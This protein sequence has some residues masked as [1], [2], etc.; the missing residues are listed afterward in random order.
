VLIIASGL[1]V[2]TF[3]HLVSADGGFNSDRALTFELTLPAASYG[4]G[5]RI[6]NLYR[7]VLQKLQALPGVASAGIGETVPMGGAGESTGLR[8]P[9][10]PAAGDLAPP[11][12]N[13]TIVSPGYLAAVGTPML[14]G[15]DFLASDT[16]DSM[17][18]A[19]V[20]AAMAKKYWPGQDAI[21][22]QVGLPIRS[23]NMTVVGVVA[24]VKHLSLREEPGPE[25]YVPFTQ[26]PWPS[27]LTMHVA[28]RTQALPASMTGAIRSAIRE[29]D[30]A[31]PMAGVATL[32][33]IVDEAMAQPR[34]S[35]LLVGG[36]GALAVL[37]ACVGLYGAVAYAV[38]SRTQEIG[39]RLALGAP[40]RRVFAL[41]LAQG[42]RITGLG[43]AA[44]VALA[45]VLLRV[46]AGF[47]YGVEATD[48]A[49]FVVV[50][51]LLL[52]VALLACYLP[53]RR[54]TRVD[55]LTAMRG[56]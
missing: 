4:D 31:L 9:D 17:P 32:E 23:F 26:K 10:R 25:I 2:R 27:M 22:K 42:V 19:I 51:T 35:M 8:I 52:G 41:V 3:T 34:F 11:Y 44:G 49:T 33:T 30:P 18:V 13:Y 1:L 46:M 28:V 37:L 38:T 48:P 47:L 39:I 14:Q 15:R 21:G 29:V 20:N 7:A 55:P 53:A 40:R 36:F 12:A 24:S 5:D 50:S 45:L 56:H 54:A 16:A 6:V 43:I